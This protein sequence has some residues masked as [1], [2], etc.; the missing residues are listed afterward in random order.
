ML[1]VVDARFEVDWSRPSWIEDELIRS[2]ARD[3]RLLE[4]DLVAVTVAARTR[5]DACELVRDLL[6]GVGAHVLEIA[7]RAPAFALAHP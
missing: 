7:E 5:P 3:A 4:D 1:V 6:D 2:G